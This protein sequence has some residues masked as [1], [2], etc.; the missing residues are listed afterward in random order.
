MEASALF[1]NHYIETVCGGAHVYFSS[2]VF[3]AIAYG[4]YV[5]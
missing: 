1:V 5:E 4:Y 3:G 2:R